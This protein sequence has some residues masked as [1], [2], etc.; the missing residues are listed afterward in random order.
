MPP[1]VHQR[2]SNE[3]ISFS[4]T[5]HPL[6]QKVFRQRPIAYA[7]EIEL[8]LNNLL[9]P[10]KFKGIDDAVRLL[11]AALEAHTINR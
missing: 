7:K 11:I 5:V 4:K 10:E 6:I 2:P 3:N 9:S 8:G 1:V